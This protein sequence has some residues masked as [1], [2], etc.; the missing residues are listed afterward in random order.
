MTMKERRLQLGYTQ[1]EVGKMCGISE[2]GYNLFETGKRIPRPQIAKKIAAVL[3]QSSM[4]SCESCIYY[5]P[6]RT[7]HCSA[8]GCCEPLNPAAC[9]LWVEMPEE[10]KQGRKGW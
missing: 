5:H 3:G 2:S 1:K 8:M 10:W 6:E 4:R 7:K 9:A